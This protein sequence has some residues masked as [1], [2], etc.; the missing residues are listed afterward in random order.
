MV[1]TGFRALLVNR[2]FPAD[3]VKKQTITI[4]HTGQCK[5]L[6]FL[7]KMPNNS[8]F[9]KTFGNLFCILIKLKFVNDSDPHKI[10]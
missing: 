9:F 4:C 10:R 2:T 8:F 1:P 6:F 3:T 5:E 7:I